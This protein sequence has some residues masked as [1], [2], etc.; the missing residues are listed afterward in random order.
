MDHL[1]TAEERFFFISRQPQLS[2]VLVFRNP[3]PTNLW[4]SSDLTLSSYTAVKFGQCCP[5]IFCC[6]YKLLIS[7]SLLYLILRFTFLSS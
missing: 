4:E 3:N 7:F 6:F 5:Y 2:E 1:Q